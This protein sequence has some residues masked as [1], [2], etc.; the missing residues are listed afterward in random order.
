[1][2]RR[3]AAGARRPA[4]RTPETLLPTV[5]QDAADGTVLGV[6]YSNRASW[7]ALQRTRELVLYSRSRQALWRKGATSG[8]TARV[9]SVA[10]DCDG[11]ALL[12]RVAPRGPYC[13]TGRRSC[14][15]ETEPV[16]ADRVPASVFQELEVLIARRQERAPRGSYTAELLR[17]DERRWKKIGEEATEVVVAAARSDRAGV[18]RESRDLLYH[19]L[20]LYAP[21]GIR[22]AEVEDALRS[23]RRPDRSRRRPTARG[24]PRPG[25]RARSSPR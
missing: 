8:N 14:F 18:I 20:V 22:W 6:A 23:R 4:F 10:V 24:G 5:V 21:L 7:R 12:V 15:D 11:D 3:R 19:L 17:D 25:V 2:N 16:P 1:M 9:V 13:H